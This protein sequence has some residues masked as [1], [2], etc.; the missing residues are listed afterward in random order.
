MIFIK[1]GE[2]FNIINPCYQERLNIYVYLKTELY[3]GC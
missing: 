3:P 1:A 2:G